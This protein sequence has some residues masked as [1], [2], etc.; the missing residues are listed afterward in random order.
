MWTVAYGGWN[1][2][3]ARFARF[4]EFELDFEGFQLWRRGSV[5]RIESLPLRLLILLVARRGELL[6][7]R[8]IEEKLWGAGVFVDVEQGINTAI[9]KIRIVLRDHPERPRFVQ[10]IVG[11]GYRFLA[12]GVVEA[13]AASTH[14]AKYSEQPMVTMEEQ[15]QA[16]L[17][18][19]GL[20]GTSA[21]LPIDVDNKDG[22]MDGDS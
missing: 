15:G 12:H 22:E 1:P 7:R 19:A 4:G 16:V 21:R 10:T 20:S 14:G 5:V 8:E 3:T 2:M 18:A 9:R 17:A 11:H 6:T 13:E